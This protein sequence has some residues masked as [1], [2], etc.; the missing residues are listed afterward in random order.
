MITC[1]YSVV[2]PVFNNAKTLKELY[3]R[4]SALFNS[5][6]NITF[7]VVFVEDGSHDD[8][9]EEIQKLKKD[10]PDTV[11][12]VRFS[13]NFGQHN[14]LL[15]GF[16]FAKGEWIITMDDDLQTPPEEISKL[17]DKMNQSGADLVYG[18]YENKQ[19]SIFR[20]TGSRF[21]KKLAPYASGNTNEGSSFRIIK[22]DIVNQI[23]T[24][25]Q[26]FVFID[27]VIFWH[28][29][30]ITSVPVMHLARKDGKSGYTFRKLMGLTVNLIINYS[31]LPLRI[32]TIVGFL[33]SFFAFLLGLFFIWK[34]V[35]YKVPLGYTSLIVTIFFSTGI[36]LLCLGILG[37]Y[38]SRIYNTQNN[39]P[40]YSIKEHV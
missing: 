4:V 24:Y 37:E 21:I 10:F 31:N 33:S 18:T 38:I 6:G 14:A 17:I 30:N 23:R 1:N 25:N 40:Q 29:A 19:H 11:R 12:G 7:E 27:E 39:K 32:M 26:P 13:R 3:S 20:N 15:C 22:K 5:F 28:T 36:I 34:K 8:S 35:H 9:W 2:V 16:R